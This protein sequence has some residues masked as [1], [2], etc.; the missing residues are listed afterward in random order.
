MVTKLDPDDV[1]KLV[2]DNELNEFCRVLNIEDTVHINRN[3]LAQK[4]ASCSRTSVLSAL[5]SINGI[6]IR[7]MRDILIYLGQ[8]G[9]SFRTTGCLLTLPLRDMDR[10]CDL[11]PQLT[12]LIVSFD[13]S[14]YKAN[15]LPDWE[16][17]ELKWHDDLSD[18]I[19]DVV[20]EGEPFRRESP[21]RDIVEVYLEM[22][23][24]GHATMYEDVVEIDRERINRI[25][26][27]WR[28]LDYLADKLTTLN[29]LNLQTAA[30]RLANEITDCAHS[31]GRNVREW[32]FD[33]EISQ[34][35]RMYVD[36]T[37]EWSDSWERQDL[38]SDEWWQYD[39]Q[40]DEWKHF[41]EDVFSLAK[42]S[43]S[44]EFSDL[45]Q[46]GMLKDRPRLFEVWCMCQILATYSEMGCTVELQ[47]LTLGQ[48]PVWNLNYSRASEPVAR[49]AVNSS[50]WWLFYQLFQKGPTRAN[51]PDLALLQERELNSG[52]IW[53]A[54]PKYSEAGSYSRA[55]Y[56]E[57]ANR[58]SDTFKAD[59]VWIYEFF[60]RRV[61]FDGA[62]SQLGDRVSILT[63][64]QPNGEGT[65]VLKSELRR[66]HRLP[67]RQLVLAIDCSGSFTETLS[68]MMET[69]ISLLDSVE[70]VICF[71]DSAKV[72]D[73]SDLAAIQDAVRMV[74]GGTCLSPLVS[75]LRALPV[76]DPVITKLL[77]I[78]DE[79]FCD[80]TLEMKNE[81][82]ELFLDTIIANDDCLY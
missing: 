9:V 57:V 32:L 19:Q 73:G 22:R 75:T 8:H 58:Y 33:Y 28:T 29:D 36:S 43:S 51:M 46:I 6:W 81:L 80:S 23:L 35:I 21:R 26:S 37:Q 54:D 47:S 44:S 76:R 3:K 68:L 41:I 25:F 63:A 78:S 11:S 53:I 24:S 79:D 50:E 66:L 71:A 7:M 13:E 40:W 20:R 31:L 17:A 1:L 34:E 5:L 42:L 45:L 56:L 72:I 27:L 61:W 62:C 30:V 38:F 18:W 67:L 39:D 65:C 2:A 55:D 16:K 52:V 59:H 14:A 49:I 4:I 74:G 48:Q 70:A 64:V 69:I 15:R 12:D 60:D 77:L 82:K 10:V